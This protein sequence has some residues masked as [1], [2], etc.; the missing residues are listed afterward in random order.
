[1]MFSCLHLCLLMQ[2]NH[3]CLVSCEQL[4]TGVYSFSVSQISHVISSHNS[5]TCLCGYSILVSVQ[6]SSSDFGT[7]VHL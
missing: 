1:M 6:W 3:A 5:D 2:L 4:L 7:G